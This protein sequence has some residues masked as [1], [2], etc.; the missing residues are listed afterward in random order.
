MHEAVPEL[1]PISDGARESI[2]GAETIRL[3]RFPFRFGRES[4]YATVN[5]ER[6]SMERRYTESQPNNEVYLIDENEVLNVSRQHFQIDRLA[7]GSYKLTD[8]GSTCGTIVD[9][10]HLGD[11]EQQS[12]APIQ[13]G[14]RVIVGTTESPFVFEFCTPDG[15]DV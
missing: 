8:R 3:I 13:S 12:E 6:V 11:K 1:K 7:D 10:H 4:R 14:S 2:E 9:G 5:G 15:P